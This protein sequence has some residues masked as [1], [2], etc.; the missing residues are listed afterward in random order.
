MTQI[1]CPD[2]MSQHHL[3]K[4]KW[5]KP[6][7]SFIVYANGTQNQPTNEPEMYPCIMWAPYLGLARWLLKTG[8]GCA[9]EKQ[10]IISLLLSGGGHRKCLPAFKLHYN[11]SGHSTFNVQSLL[12]RVSLSI[13]SQI[14]LIFQVAN[15]ASSPAGN[16]LWTLHN[17]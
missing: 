13:S 7:V 4:K 8:E 12:S 14:L 1:K 3:K 10:D 16:V 2:T 5:E 11:V 15:L 9:H 6:R 17:H